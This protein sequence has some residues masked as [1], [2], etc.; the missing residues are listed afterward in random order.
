MR[1]AAK[2]YLEKG[3]A[4]PPKLRHFHIIDS[5]DQATN[6]YTPEPYEGNVLM[7]KAR[8]S[9]GPSDM[10]WHA[11]AKGSFHTVET[12]GDHYNMIKEPHVRT[13]ARLVEEGIERA[14]RHAAAE[15]G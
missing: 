12:P 6:R 8:A 11:Y 7:I 3:K 9:A 1:R 5:Y 2:W 14:L 13:L 4:L 10:G 15:A